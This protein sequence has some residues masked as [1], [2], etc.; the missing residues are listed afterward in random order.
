MPNIFELIPAMLEQEQFDILQKNKHIKIERIISK[1]H[2]SPL[3]GWYDQVQSEWLIVL[4]GEAIIEF[5]GEQVKT[6]LKAGD[7]LNIAPHQRHKVSWTDPACE[8]IWLAVHY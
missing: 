3:T 4:Q 7:Y 2:S 6:V 1:G 8:T 5:E